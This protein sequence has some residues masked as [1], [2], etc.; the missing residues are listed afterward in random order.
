MNKKHKFHIPVLGIGYSIDTP[1]KVAKYGIS[2]VVSLVDDSLLE[3]MRE[4]YSKK[5]N[6]EFNEIDPKDN[7]ARAKRVTAYLNMLNTMVNEQLDELKK[8]KFNAENDL[9][10]YFEM[11]PDFSDLKKKYRELLT[12]VDGVSFEKLQAWLKENISLG[13][14]DVNIMTKL[15]KTNRTKSGE[16]LSNEYND[17]HA[18]LRGFAES[19]LEGSVI[20]SAGMNPRLYSYAE[21]FNDFYPDL[22]GNIRKKIVLKVSDFRSALIQGKFLAKKGLWVSEYRIESGLNCGGHAF[23]TDG[24]LLGP[25]LEEFKSKKTELINM[26]KNLL[27]QA[28]TKKGIRYNGEKLGLNI[29]VQGGVGTESEHHFLQRYYGMDSVGWG[30]PFMLVPEIMNVDENTL[31]KLSKAEEKDLYLSGASPLG[32]PFNNLRGS[33]QELEKIERL[34]NGRPGSPCTK[35]FLISNTEYSDKPQC[36]ASISY[37]TKKINELKDKYEINTDFKKE[38]DKVVEKACLCV[39]L[40]ASTHKVNKLDPK[41]LSK[42]V[43]VCPG[44]NM[45]YFSK[46]AS[47][48]EMVDHIYGRANLITKKERPNIFIK[49]LGLYFDYLVNKVK[50]SENPLAGIKTKYLEEFKNNMLD[51]INYYKSL[52]PNLEEESQKIKERMEKELADFEAKLL[53]LSISL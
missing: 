26:V 12:T 18:A 53:S 45:A 36:T 19:D 46:K 42:A 21:K 40:G 52:L 8:M 23:A 48:F 13:S 28:L 24:F 29:T 1:L 39:G 17:A 7:D 31:E 47:L 9:A 34:K 44:P 49:E 30:T 32:V 20:F 43:S 2:S 14:I 25:I 38:F 15:D 27:D 6:K 51:G 10:K 50:E 11:L 3:K 4:Y 5:T 37:V 16:V 22:A 33:E 41:K 35:K